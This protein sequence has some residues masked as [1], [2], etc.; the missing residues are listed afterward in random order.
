MSSDVPQALWADLNRLMLPTWNG[1]P[2]AV[3]VEMGMMGLLLLVMKRKSTPHARLARATHVLAVPQPGWLARR[4][5]AGGIRH[6]P[7]RIGVGY[8][9]GLFGTIELTLEELNHHG[10]SGGASGS[11]KTTMLRGLVQGYPGPVIVLDCK[12]DQ[13]LV[14]TMWSVPG[15][16][17]EIGGPLRLDLLDPEPAILAQQMLEGEE[18][19]DRGAVYRAIAEHAVIRAGQV[20][21]WR[22]EPLDPVRI[23]ELVSSPST[24]AEAIRDAMP[25]GDRTAQR[26]LAELDEASA[27]IREGLQTFAERLGTL[28][29]SPAGRSLGAGADALRLADVL[30]TNG[31]LLIRLD[32]RY[33]AISRKMGAWALVAMLRLATELRQ[34]RWWGRCLFLVDDPRLLRHEGR[35]L[36]D[37]FGTARDAGIGMV[38][39]DQGIAG[40]REV[41]PDLPDAVLRST[42]WQLIFRQGSPTDAEKMA[43]LFGTT[44]REDVSYGS[45]GRTTTR[46]R[47]EPRVYPSW[48]Q[49]LPT[50]HAWFHGAPIGMNARERV[51]VLVVATPARP[52]RPARLA[53]PPGHP[54]A[55]EETA[56]AGGPRPGPPPTAEELARAAVRRLIGPLRQDGCREWRG[57]Y[58]K[59]GYGRAWYH[60][61]KRQAHRLLAT[62]E[63]GEVPRSWEVDHTC[64]H[65]WCVEITHLEPISRAEHRRRE[66]ERR[67]LLDEDEIGAEV[68]ATEHEASESEDAEGKTSTEPSPEKTASEPSPVE[69]RRVAV[70]QLRAQGL[71]LRRIAERLG[72]SLGTAHADATGGVQSGVQGVQ[73]ERSAEHPR[74]TKAGFEFERQDGGV[75]GADD[76]HGDQIDRADHRE[77]A[78]TPGSGAGADLE[79]DNGVVRDERS[80]ETAAA[81]ESHRLADTCGTAGRG[82]EIALFAGVDRPAVE[83]RTVGL[84]EL[85]RLLTTFTEL[86]DKRQARCWAPTRYA[87]GVSTR[88]N[89]GVEAVTCLVFDCDRVEPDWARLEAYW[90]LAHTTYQHTPEHP[91]WRLVLPLAA[92]V[93]ATHWPATWRR[94]HHALCPESDPNCKDASRQYYLPSHPVGVQTES[95]CHVR[96]LLEPARLPDLPA[97]RA[98]LA[99]RRLPVA[100][101]PR[102]PTERERRRGEAYLAKVIGDL[103]KVA[104][105]GRNDALNRAAWKL[106]QWVAA[107]ALNQAAVEDALFAAAERNGLVSDPQDGPRKTWATIRSG[108]SK[109]LQ[110]PVDFDADRW[111]SVQ[112][113]RS[114]RQP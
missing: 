42:G 98:V 57:S 88:G 40:L 52:E 56:S 27:T 44:W 80:E 13:Q 89:D 37:L 54:P 8:E 71:S 55:D 45:D 30:A 24:L 113:R 46:L 82:L 6:G 70:Q 73:T 50:G 43:A 11:G 77:P 79:P 7:D 67:H 108:L 66:A 72:I 76:Q 93:A 114:R 61:H 99:M 51:G 15:L 5:A 63:Y 107:G 105:G 14:E 69:Q 2:V 26:W 25:V 96:R 29:D 101:V 94:A 39:A 62:W 17:W 91:R 60:G 36:A 38:V 1:M 28:L 109:G 74:S 100:S 112:S 20:L 78:A 53:L 103:A 102:E 86:A 49:S 22:A 106:G 68:S 58:D 92:P 16:V 59:D 110:Q 104:A 81:G 10:Y 85:S 32:P 9:R 34:A 18:Y 19:G 4:R 87:D 65:R 21:R 47:E 111:P 12:G 31:K 33:G 35:W 95:R 23:L 84:D 90:Y 83:Q 64:R 3:L 75:R 41:H 97:E 48:L